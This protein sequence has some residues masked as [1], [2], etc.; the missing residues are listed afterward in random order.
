MDAIDRVALCQVAH[1]GL[2]V[3]GGGRGDR[4]GVESFE[5]SSLRAC[6]AGELADVSRAVDRDLRDVLGD[7]ARHHQPLGV[8]V[9]QVIACN[10]QIDRAR[11]Q[12]DVDPGMHP[13]SR[14]VR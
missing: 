10:R 9:D 5:L 4:R 1:D 6:P 12:V 13:K 11:H 7:L 8:P 14:S 3:V 2:K